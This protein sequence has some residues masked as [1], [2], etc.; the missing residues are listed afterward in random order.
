M[1]EEEL[2]TW[3][4]IAETRE[5]VGPITMSLTANDVT[6]TTEDF[7]VCVVPKGSR[8]T[9]WQ[10]PDASQGGE[11]G[12]LVGADTPYP[13]TPGPTYQIYARHT[14]TL[15]IPVVLVGQIKAK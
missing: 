13:L 7:E 12:V 10:A 1:A 2:T 4:V 5:W 6:T 9:A 14:S 11:L 3:T 15:E 8:P